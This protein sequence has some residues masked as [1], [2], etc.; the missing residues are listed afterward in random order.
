MKV[1]IEK[2]NAHTRPWPSAAVIGPAFATA[3]AAGLGAGAAAIFGSGAGAAAILGAGAAALFG[4]IPCCRCSTAPK[5]KSS[6]KFQATSNY[7]NA[8]I[9]NFDI[10]C[11]AVLHFLTV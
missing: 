4:A 6:K 10:W 7:R 8:N 1:V 3:R 5:S 9:S 11:L 2:W